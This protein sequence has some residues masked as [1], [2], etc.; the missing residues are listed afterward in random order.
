MKLGKGVEWTAHTCALL[1]LLPPGAAL[2]GEA[3]ADFL[4]VP[5]PYLAK[6][7]QAL[8]RAGIVTAKRGAAGGYRL[9]RPP[10]A[11][12]LWDVTAAIEGTAPS[13]RCTEVRRSG[14][15]GA[16]PAECSGPCPIAAAFQRAEAG[17]RQALAAVTLTDVIA[18]VAQAATSARKRRIGEWIQQHAAHPV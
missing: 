10:E 15:C 1:A 2:P 13:F 5:P 16:S 7:L 18:G 14:P 11:L 4:G 9:A 17:Y 12:S 3:L 6:Q 8:S